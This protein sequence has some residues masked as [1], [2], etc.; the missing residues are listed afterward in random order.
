MKEIRTFAAVLQSLERS[1][2]VSRRLCTAEDAGSIPASP[3]LGERCF[4][5]HRAL[6]LLPV[7]F[8]VPHDLVFV[9]PEI[10]PVGSLENT[11]LSNARRPIHLGKRET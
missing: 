8:K 2:K 3:T 1:N 9:V 7:Y 4:P 11:L 5:A 10:G 6:P